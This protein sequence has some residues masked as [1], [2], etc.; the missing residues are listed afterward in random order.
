MTSSSITTT[1][2]TELDL[3]EVKPGVSFGRGILKTLLPDVESVLFF[4][5]IQQLDAGQLGRLLHIVLDTDLTSALF[6][7]GG[8]HSTDLQGYLLDGYTDEDGNWHEPIVAAAQQGEIVLKPIIPAGEILPQ[9]W[10]QLR[11]EVATSI[12][13][14]AAKLTNVV[15]HL[16]G[17]KGQMI[18]AAM[19][20]INA[21]R[22]TIGD[23]RAAITHRTPLPNLVIMDVSGSMSSS[24]VHRIVDDVVALSYMANA[25]MAVVSN[26]TTYWEP[27]SFDVQAVLN[28]SEFGGTQYETLHELLNSNQWGTVVTI[29]D[30]DSSLAARDYLEAKVTSSIEELLDIS[31]VNQP[32]FLAECLRPF[33]ALARPLLIGNSGYVLS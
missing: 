21:R 12:S 13:D 25:Y 27:G 10:D 22:P 7:E 17:K 32:T 29:A 6:D 1:S 31:L 15:D 19:R 18:F 9:V 14:V 11:V 2:S 3:V 20:K 5:K 16:D 28:A 26:T 8:E 4:G 23:F 30:Y 24:T 33:A